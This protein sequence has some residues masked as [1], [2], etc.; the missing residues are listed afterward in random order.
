MR[1]YQLESTINEHGMIVL[2]DEMK[3]LKAHRVRLTIVDLEE[4][5]DP[6]DFL[7]FITDKYS[8]LTEPDLNLSEMYKRRE[9][10]NERR[11]EFD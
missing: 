9:I 4:I 3:N 8:Q 7:D 2:P 10:E 1:T 11:I 5:S 6:L